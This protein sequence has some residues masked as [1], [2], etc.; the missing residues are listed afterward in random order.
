MQIAGVVSNVK[1]VGMNE[2]D[3]NDI[4]LPFAQSPAPSIQ[5]IVQHRCP[6]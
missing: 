3:F 2:I 4:Y 6:A 1:D 5:L